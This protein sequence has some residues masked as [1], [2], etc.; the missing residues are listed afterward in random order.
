MKTKNTAVQTASLDNLAGHI[1]P[2]GGNVF[3]DL[4]FEPAEAAAL[5]EQSQKAIAKKLAIKAQLMDTLAT[6]MV[7]EKLTQAKAATVLGIS[8]PRVSDVIRHKNSN[9]TV[10]ALID[11]VVRTGRRVQI[12]V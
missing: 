12:S 3:A 4:G 8:R 2:V 11:M 10:D 7:S 5:F 1:T 6:W 9:F